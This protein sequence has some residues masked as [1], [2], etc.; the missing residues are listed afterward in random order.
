[1][2]FRSTLRKAPSGTEAATA[3][4]IMHRQVGHMVRLVD[5]LLDVARITTGKVEVR[6]DSLDVVSAV[7]DALETTQPVVGRQRIS[8]VTPTDALYVSADRT[9]LAQVFANLLNNAAKYS[10]QDQPIV[11]TV[12]REGGEAVVRVRDHGI[13]IE[14]DM[15]PRV[16][17]MFRQ[18]TRSGGWTRG[19]LGIG[20]SLVKRIVEL[21]GG[22]VTA[23]SEGAG[24]GSEFVVRLPI[25]EA[26]ATR[27]QSP[28]AMTATARE[29]RRRVLV[30][31]DNADSAE[32]LS[33]LLTLSGHETRIA[34]DGHGALEQA[35][36]FPPDVVFLD[37]GMPGM[38]GHETARRI[39][40]RAWGHDMVLVALTGWDQDEDRR[41]SKAAGFDVHLVKPADPG[42][43]TALLASLG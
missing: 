30:V 27:T 42:D 35:E 22:T 41:R 23:H 18:V 5:D 10:D 4:D 19:G 17:E 29:A 2:L 15:L 33:T 1:M 24:H 6:Q 9:R 8:I 26:P 7:N 25:V 14:P 40:E 12:G 13:G 11:L 16:F 20:L 43:V 34:H 38:D 3:L 28:T 21:H 31:D 39:R 32:S 37:I 36:V